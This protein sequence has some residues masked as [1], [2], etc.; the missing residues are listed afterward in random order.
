MT[1]YFSS[2]LN[3]F[4]VLCVTEI[5]TV[6]LRILNRWNAERTDPWGLQSSSWPACATLIIC[7][8]NIALTFHL[9][10]PP[11][12]SHW[13]NARRPFDCISS[14]VYF[15]PL[16]HTGL[17]ADWRVYTFYISAPFF[18]FFLTQVFI[19]F[20]IC[21]FL[22]TRFFCYILFSFSIVPFL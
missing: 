16:R 13:T 8:A 17:N 1:I 7:A 15:S 14:N 10:R 4:V 22:F 9:S 20:H 11:L 6:Q 12:P 19:I 2:L 3:H 5:Y 18:T 21:A